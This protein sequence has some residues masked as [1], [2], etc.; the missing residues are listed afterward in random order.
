VAVIPG[1]IVAG[2]AAGDALDLADDAGLV[3]KPRADGSS[4]GLHLVGSAAELPA[5]IAAERGRLGPVDFLVERRLP[6]PEYTV[7]VLDDP[8]GVRALPP[9]SIVP[10]GE[11]YDYEAK[12]VSDATAYLFPEEAALVAELEELGLAAH[13]AC[14]CRH[15]SRVDFIAD[16]DGRPR[17]LEINTLPGFTSHSLLPKAAAR[18]GMDF[19]ALVDHLVRLAAGEEHA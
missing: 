6:G 3:L 7:G 12:Y 10:A 5:L 9:I 8:A 14:G 19:A 18:A 15:F 17:F 1:A 13:R 2:D 16:E 4:V 11:A